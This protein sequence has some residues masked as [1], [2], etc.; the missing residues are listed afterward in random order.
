MEPQFDELIHVPARLSIVALLNPAK[1][2]EFR[3]LR[4]ELEMRDSALS[5]HISALESAGY[6][7]VR[8]ERAVGSTRRTL[9]SLTPA[10]R[11]AFDG[12]VAALEQIVAA[13]RGEATSSA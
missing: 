1:W 3:F 2:V 13:S 12:H 9:I 11:T 10:G 5:K 6:V 8:K 7:E 4:D